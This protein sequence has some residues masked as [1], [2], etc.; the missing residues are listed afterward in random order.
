[1]N[2]ALV[3]RLAVEFQGFCRDL[4]DAAAD[5]FSSWA[6]PDDARLA[7]IIRASMTK[8][9]LLDRGNATRSR[10][11]DDFGRFG[12]QV[13]QI[14]SERDPRMRRWFVDL[15]RL[16]TARNAIAHDNPEVLAQLDAD[17]QALTLTTLRRWRGA[18]AGLAA[19]LDIVT[20]EHLA[21]TFGREEPW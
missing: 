13:S 14:L 20:A 21:E 10:L 12:M 1:M 16:N 8:A 9:R 19:T 15:E 6:A 5:T 17:G 7:N 18:L 3:L 2:H 11:T 4:H